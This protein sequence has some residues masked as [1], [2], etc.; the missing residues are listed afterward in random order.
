MSTG[1]AASGHGR[2]RIC[3]FGSANMDLVVYADRAPDSGETVTG[4]RFHT[5]PGGK[6]ANQAIAAARAGGAVSMV[7]AVGTDAHGE[8][9][10]SVL[11]DA[12]VDVDG[13]TRTEEPTGTAHIVVEGDGGN[14]IVVVPGANGTVATAP[15]ALATALRRAD[16]LVMQLELP[17]PAVCAGAALA[18]DLGVPVVLTPAPARPLPAELSDHVRLLVPNEH[19]ATMLGGPERLLT[20]LPSLVVT[21][22]SA[23][24]TWY[25]PDAEP[26]TVPAYAAP[27]RDSTAAG[28]SFVGA[29]VV[30]LGEGASV[31]DAMRW[32]T[33]AAAI[34]VSREGASASMP[35]R[36]EIDAYPTG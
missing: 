36:S 23:G 18:A 28:D 21:Q 19:E 3:V 4:R 26:V 16:L 5:V 22:G 20:R 35:T 33:A 34:A 32:A 15:P 13:I 2:P 8:A 25:R 6:G 12:G 30:A 10:L 11:R 17:L 29:L 1:M 31:P 7:G 24:A 9:L 27:V 14:R